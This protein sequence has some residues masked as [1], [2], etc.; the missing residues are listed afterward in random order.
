MAFVFAHCWIVSYDILYNNYKHCNSNKGIFV[1]KE[2]HIGLPAKINTRATYST[3]R[4]GTKKLHVAV[5][6]RM[7]CRIE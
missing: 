7:A 2:K 5:D 1:T 6:V 3:I 4:N